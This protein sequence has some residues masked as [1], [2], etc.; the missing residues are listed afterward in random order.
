MTAGLVAVF[1]SVLVAMR[2][3]RRKMSKSFTINRTGKNLSVRSRSSP[4]VRNYEMSELAG[5]DEI[6]EGTS[7][8][9]TTVSTITSATHLS[10]PSTHCLS[11]P[12][13]MNSLEED[14]TL[15]FGETYAYSNRKTPTGGMEKNCEDDNYDPPSVEN[16]AI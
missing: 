2:L 13:N 4:R 16:Y 5:N 15:C 7:R 10:Q 12:P 11:K 6:S 3:Y 14:E 1:I 8:P 9:E